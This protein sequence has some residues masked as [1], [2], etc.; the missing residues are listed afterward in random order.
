LLDFESYSETF[1]YIR[2]SGLPQ[3]DIHRI[4][5]ENAPRVLGLG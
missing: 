3:A 5:H 4:L 2:K 1:D